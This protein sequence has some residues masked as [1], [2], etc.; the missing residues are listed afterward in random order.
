[1]IGG[2]AGHDE[3]LVDLA[4]LLVGEALLVEH[5]AA[6]TKWPSRVSATAAG[7]SA[8]SLSMKYS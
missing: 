5:D 3:H 7:C 8:I 1:M 4:Q 2:A 6:S